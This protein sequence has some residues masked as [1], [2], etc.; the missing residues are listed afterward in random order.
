MNDAIR[1]MCRDYEC[2]RNGRQIPIDDKSASLK[3]L[4]ETI[5]EIKADWQAIPL[6]KEHQE[7]KLRFYKK[8][9]YLQSKERELSGGS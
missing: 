8:M 6:T 9:K 3:H 4:R 2:L 1:K 5:A 7:K